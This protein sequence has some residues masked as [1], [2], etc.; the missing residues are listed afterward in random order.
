MA[1]INQDLITSAVDAKDIADAASTDLNLLSALAMPDVFE[2]NW[3][4]IFIAV[5]AWLLQ[6]IKPARYFPNMAP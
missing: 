4:R 1:E 2:F 5:W 6:E 3:S